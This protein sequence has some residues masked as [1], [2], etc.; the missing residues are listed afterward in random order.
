[1][2]FYTGNYDLGPYLEPSYEKQNTILCI[3]AIKKPKQ[4]PVSDVFMTIGE[5]VPGQE[6]L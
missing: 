3:C 6:E 5:V 1:M 4:N 2:F